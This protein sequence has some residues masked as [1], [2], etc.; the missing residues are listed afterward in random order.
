MKNLE[1]FILAIILINFTN[2]MKAKEEIH[3]FDKKNE[4]KAVEVAKDLTVNYTLSIPEPHTHY[5]E[6]TMQIDNIDQDETDIKMPVWT[7]GSYLVREFPKNVEGFKAKNGSNA[8]EFNKIAKHTWR[9]NTKDVKSMQVSYKVYAYELSVRTSYVTSD[10]AYLNGTSIFMYVDDRVDLPTT[11]SIEPYGTWKQISTGLDNDGHKWTLTAPNYDVLADSPIL[12]GNHEIHEF[13]A[14]GIPHYIAID[15]EGNY[16]VEQ[17]KKDFIKVAD[18]ETELFGEHP[19]EHYTY[20]VLNTENSYGGL[21][22]LNST[23]LIFPRWGYSSQ[24]SY[25]KFVSLAAHEYFHLWNVKRI[26]PKALGPF[27]YQNENYTNLL[28]VMEGFTSY[29]D[30]YLLRRGG[31]LSAEQ[32]LNNMLTKVFEYCE[33]TPGSEVQSLTQSSFD[34]WIK[35]YRKNENTNNC[36]VSYYQKG[37]AVTSLLDLAI[38]HETKGAKSLDDVMR[39]LYQEFYKKQQRGFTDEEMQKT[40]EDI[41]GTSFQEFFDSYIYG[42]KPLDYNKYLG[43]VG[44]EITDH[45][46]GNTNPYLGASIS[47][48]EGRLMVKSIV[49]NTAAWH[50]DL[51]VNDEVIAINGYRVNDNWGK[52]IK[53]QKPGDTVELTINR[54]GKLRTLQLELTNNPKSSFQISKKSDASSAEKKLYEEWLSEEF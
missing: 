49:R 35:Y 23:S 53:A 34:A 3:F 2:S 43:Y 1:L 51:N 48:D 27:D 52:F 16:D 32:Y 14:Q 31:W 6:V 12:I 5:V 26:R 10:K 29:Y 13:T 21:E 54:D 19:C 37:A 24:N 8:L 41:A 40:I 4:V 15:G 7:P 44:L 17:M 9:I 18:V 36:C 39:Y 46:E 33:N 47:L 28:W 25:M 42:C 22:H 30:E 20:I 50:G 38:R 45:N 11:V